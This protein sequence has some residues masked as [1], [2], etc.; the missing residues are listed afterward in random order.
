MALRDKILSLISD[1]DDPSLRLEISR[2]ITFLYEVWR[3]GSVSEEEIL[4]SLYEVAYTIVSYK[5]P[6]LTEEDKRSKAREIAEDIM[7]SFRMESLF[8]R[9][10][11][12]LRTVTL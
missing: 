9:T 2:T 4:S 12:R 10:F 6:F 11:R 5:M 1:I 8:P 3:S 7:R